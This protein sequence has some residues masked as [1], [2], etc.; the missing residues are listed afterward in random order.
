MNSEKK[1]L[2]LEEILH[3]EAVQDLYIE[4]LERWVKI[5]NASTRDRLEAERLAALHPSW[6]TMSR[7]DKDLTIGKMLALQILVEPKIS[8]EDYLNS[9]DLEMQILIEAVANAYALKLLKLQEQRGINLRRFLEVMQ[10][11]D[12]LS[13][14]SSLNLETLTGKEQPRSGKT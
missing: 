6:P 3:S 12:L 5:K 8:Y 10:G 4:S 11:R 7:E 9:N 1:Y 14:T 2:S 13:S